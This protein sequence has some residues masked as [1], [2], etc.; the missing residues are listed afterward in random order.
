MSVT[1]TPEHDELVRRATD[2]AP[3]L[4]KHA[5]WSE[6]NRRLHGEVVEAIAASG[7]YRMRKPSRYGGYEVS[8]RTLVAVGAALARGDASAGWTTSIHTIP[9]WMAG[10]FPDQVQDE[11][12]ANP[13]E[14]ICGTL[15]PS[16]VATPAPG[17]A[18]VDGTWRFVS[19]AQH[20]QWQEI[21]A[22]APTPDGGQQP[23]VA[24]VPM[25][26]L[27]VID[28]WHASGL[29]GSGSVTTVAEG[30]FVPEERIM[31]LMEMLEQKS[32]SVANAGNLMYRAP[33]MPVTAAAT[34]GTLLGLARAAMDSFTERMVHRKITYTDYASQAE[35]PVTHLQLAEASL[36]TDQADFH[37]FRVAEMLDTKARDGEPWTMLE[38][39]RSRADVGVVSDLSKQAID[40]LSSAS[41]GSS[42]YESE[43][44]QRVNRNIQAV[45][46]HALIYPTTAYELYG[47]VLSGLEANTLYV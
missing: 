8:G 4:E 22:M 18:I 46:L 44:I 2:L 47:R 1:P 23:V 11:I 40:I 26:D 36:K 15:S 17:G 30:V 37:S 3:L 12:F 42:I 32:R 7:L 13:D 31:P 19:G 41:G 14:R 20:S 16:A 5:P 35:A 27:R 24:L 25:T 45:N 39:A 29:R 9:G 43:P 38:R 21:L 33:L 6:E 28:D 34:V 10:M